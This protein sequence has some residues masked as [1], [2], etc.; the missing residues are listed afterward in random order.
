MAKRFKDSSEK[1]GSINQRP[2]K[3]NDSRRSDK[4]FS[5]DGFFN[6]VTGAQEYMGMPTSMRRGLEDEP[7]IHEDHRAIA[8]L[9]QEVMIKSYPQT[10]PYMPEI[11]DDTQGGV[12]AQMDYDDKQRRSHFYPKKV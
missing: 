6:N 1:S 9:P 12:N 4:D 3:F 8:N 10:G 2:S 7:M 5:Q 11:L